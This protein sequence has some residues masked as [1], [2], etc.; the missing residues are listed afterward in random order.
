MSKATI[1]IK[2][3][4]NKPTAAFYRCFVCDRMED[5]DQPIIAEGSCL[6]GTLKLC[7]GCLA[8]GNIDNLLAARANDLMAD[9][10][11]LRSLI[12]RLRVPTYVEWKAANDRAHLIAY[13]QFGE[14]PPG[15]HEGS[16]EAIIDEDDG[17]GDHPF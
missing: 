12:G 3:V 7:T 11:T 15:R 9:A 10:Q 4:S 13:Q 5:N 1:D 2:L 16:P 17:R 14:E 6:Y 8:A